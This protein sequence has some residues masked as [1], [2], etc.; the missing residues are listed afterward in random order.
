MLSRWQ[1]TIV[2]AKGNVQPGAV[3][4]VRNEADQSL[5]LV[6]QANNDLQ[7]YPLGYVTA[8]ANGFAYFYAAPGRYRIQSVDLDID[9]RDVEIGGMAVARAALESS[10]MSVYGT[11][12]EMQADTPT[13]S[14]VYAR[15]VN[16]VDPELNGYYIWDGSVWERTT[17]Q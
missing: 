4:R 17:E 16:D 9:W 7:P 11:Q 5:A 2:D 12:A 1:S 13:E 3:L 14:P 10:G 6:H 8:N 15:V